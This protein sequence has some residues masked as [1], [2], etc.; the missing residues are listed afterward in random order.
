[1]ISVDNDCGSPCMAVLSL[2]DLYLDQLVAGNAPEIEAYLRGHPEYA[3]QLRPVL[4]GA[5]LV[6]QEVRRLRLRT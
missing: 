3:G 2:M 4:E 1:M 6:D 5:V